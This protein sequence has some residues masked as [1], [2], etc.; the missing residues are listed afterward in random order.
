MQE[1]LLN[2]RGLFPAP[3]DDINQEVSERPPLIHVSFTIA[4]VNRAL[5]SQL[6][7]DIPILGSTL[8]FAGSSSTRK[9]QGLLQRGTRI[10]MV[11]I[12]EHMQLIEIIRHTNEARVGHHVLQVRHD[13]IF[14]VTICIEEH[15]MA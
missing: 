1:E 14:L 9:V 2:I 15:H 8:R 6:T 12:N 3:G 11:P 4:C 7:I 10:L 5:H 13:T